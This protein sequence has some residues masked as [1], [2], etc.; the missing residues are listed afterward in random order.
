[1]D[2]WYRY[3]KNLNSVMRHGSV[4]IQMALSTGLGYLLGSWLDEKFQTAPW[5]M[6]ALTLLGTASGFWNLFRVYRGIGRE[7]DGGGDGR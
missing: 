4:G 3:G 1:M 6:L 7:A 5:L 2:R